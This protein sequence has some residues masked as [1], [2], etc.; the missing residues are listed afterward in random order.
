MKAVLYKFPYRYFPYE[1]RLL[2]AE[3]RT[4]GQIT[5]ESDRKIE[6]KIHRHTRRKA[7]G[8][9]LR[10]LTYFSHYQLESSHLIA[11]RQ[12][13]FETIAN[14]SSAPQRRQSTR[15]STHGVHEY[16][17]KFN[18]QIVR[19]LIN[20]SEVRPGGFI[21]DPFC[22]SGTVLAEAVHKVNRTKIK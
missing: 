7:L 9:R 21:F 16:K 19:H 8:N 6:V 10:Q 15:Y 12:F 5:K 14:G 13:L 18:P 20:R 4:F 1:E 2:E 22:G 17:G 11:T 3:A